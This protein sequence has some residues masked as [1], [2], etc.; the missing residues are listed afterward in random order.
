MTIV[1]A[2]YHQ[3]ALQEAQHLSEQHSKWKRGKQ[4]RLE[5]DDQAHLFDL[6]LHWPNAFPPYIQTDHTCEAVGHSH[7]YNP[8]TPQT[9]LCQQVT[10]RSMDMHTDNSFHAS[11]IK[12]NDCFCVCGHRPYSIWNLSSPTRGLHPSAVEVWN[13]NPWTARES[14]EWLFSDPFIVLNLWPSSWQEKRGNR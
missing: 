4:A 12:K 14:Q 7:L 5:G 1:R 9:V 11:R 3:K 2:H 13:P 10:I 6:Q 8:H